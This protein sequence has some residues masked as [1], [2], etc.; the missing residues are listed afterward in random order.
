[1]A[2]RQ[3]FIPG[4]RQPVAEWG[5]I[6][7]DSIMG[8]GVSGGG[9]LGFQAFYLL[10]EVQGDTLEQLN[11]FSP[12]LGFAGLD[13][14]RAR[15]A[16]GDS[17]PGGVVIVNAVAIRADFR[18]ASPW[19]VITGSDGQ[20]GRWA[21]SGDIRDIRP[22]E[23]GWGRLEVVP[24]IRFAGDSVDLVT[25][26]YTPGQRILTLGTYL[27]SRR[28]MV[29]AGLEG[30]VDLESDSLSGVSATAGMVSTG[31]VTWDM[32]LSVFA[33]G[34]YSGTLATGISDGFASA[35]M[36]LEVI[37]DSTRLNGTA[38]YS[39]RRDVCAEISVAGDLDDSLQPSCA[40]AVSS[41]LGPVKGLLAVDWTYG[42]SPVFRLNLRGFL[43]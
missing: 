31:G 36:M 29:S 20:A 34:D 35:G 42:S 32:M 22:F 40:V 19:L 1:Y 39:P 5:W 4:L 18:Y 17:I 6:N 15:L 30:M 13:Y 16:S 8:F 38:S 9:I 11:V 21:L 3:P 12:W 2:D 37:D 33:D 28:Y 43:R 41:A 23:T 26:A 25:D 10:Q 27:E 14:Y 24:G 7:A